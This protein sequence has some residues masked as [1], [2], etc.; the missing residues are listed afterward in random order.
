MNAVHIRQATPDDLQTLLEFE[1]GIIN[2]ERPFDITLKREYTQY[3]DLAFMLRAENVFIALA[4]MDDKPVGCGYAR[5]EAAKP[6]LQHRL[7]A[8]LGFM[9]VL[10]AYRGKGINRRVIDVLK[11]WAKSR[12]ITELRLEVYSKNE[13]AISAYQKAGFSGLL[14]EMRMNLEQQEN[15]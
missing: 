10:P 12:G 1:Q 9:Y 8:Y 3:Y 7:H 11:T 6:Y 15:S 13:A 4:E 5:I 14:L 2:A